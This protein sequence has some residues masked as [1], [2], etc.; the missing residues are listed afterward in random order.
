MAAAGSKT[1]IYAA[2]TGN[3]AIAATKFVA[4]A[5]TG[6]SAMLSEGIHSVVDTG[7]GLLLL[8]GIRQ[9]QKPPDETHPFGRGKELYFWTLIVAILVFAIGGGISVLEGMNHLRN[10]QPLKDPIW[11]YI[12]LGLAL[13]FEGLA[14][15]VAY[16]EFR[17]VKGGA[18]LLG[19]GENQ[20]GS[21]HILGVV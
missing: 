15:T 10:P 13:I 4:A 21:N 2:I 20:Q 5:V 6:S 1:V 17:K 3:L 8:Y 14:W 19:C 18:G 9:S 11:N 7:N 16:R 12:V